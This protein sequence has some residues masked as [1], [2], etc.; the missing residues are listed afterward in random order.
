M[1]EGKRKDSRKSRNKDQTI[2]YQN[3]R[4]KQGTA[5][6]NQ[7]MCMKPPTGKV[8]SLVGANLPPPITYIVIAK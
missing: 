1:Y 7:R 6:G 8:S 3:M 2:L 5:G 4:C